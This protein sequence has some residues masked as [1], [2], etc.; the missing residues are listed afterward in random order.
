[1]HRNR[2]WNRLWNLR[3]LGL[4]EQEDGIVSSP[5]SLRCPC[6]HL[7]LGSYYCGV[8]C[9]NENGIRFGPISRRSRR[10][11][12]LSYLFWGA[13][14]SCSG[15]TTFYTRTMLAIIKFANCPLFRF[16]P[17]SLSPSSAL[18]LE[19]C[20]QVFANTPFVAIALPSGCADNRPVR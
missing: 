13:G 11:A 9:G 19:L 17:S 7:R 10:G 18:T 15:E 4:C 2:K 5:V 16:S 3:N 12:R 8:S 1:M 6:T 14:G 20:R